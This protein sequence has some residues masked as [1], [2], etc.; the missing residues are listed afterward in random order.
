MV[1]KHDLEPTFVLLTLKGITYAFI[2][3]QNLYII[4]LV[5]S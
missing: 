2:N 5:T 1:H 4:T 3:L